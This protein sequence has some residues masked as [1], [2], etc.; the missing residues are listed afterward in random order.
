[1]IWIAHSFLGM[2]FRAWVRLV[3]AFACVSSAG[4]AACSSTEGPDCKHDPELMF[5]TDAFEQGAVYPAG[6]CTL[7]IYAQKTVTYQFACDPCEAGVTNHLSCAA[8]AT[9]APSIDCE[10]N[11]HQL[12][13][14]EEGDAAQAVFDY[15]G[16]ANVTG[17]FDCTNRGPITTY[18]EGNE[19]QCYL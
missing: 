2:T 7:T 16:D 15:V 10:W 8:D 13:V 19:T 14:R 6:P 9:S 11:G 3:V 5:F 4:A 12:G 18:G 1:M 17:K